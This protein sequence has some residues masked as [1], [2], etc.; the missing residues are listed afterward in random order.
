VTKQHA[1]PKQFHVEEVLLKGR[2]KE[3]VE[4]EEG[5][6]EERERERERERESKR[7]G[8]VLLIYM[9]N[10]ITQVRV[11]GKPN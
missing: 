6:R 10:D 9:E 1:R 11:R 3:V 2:D 4:R 5:A 7:G 8:G